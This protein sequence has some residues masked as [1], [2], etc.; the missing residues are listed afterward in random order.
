MGLKLAIGAAE[1]AKS[2]GVKHILTISVLT[3]SLTDTIYG[4]QYNE[5]ELK[6]QNLEMPYTIIRL[7][8]FVDNYWG[9]KLPIQQ[10]SSFGTP[11]DPTKP[12]SAVVV[13]DAGKAAAAIM[14]RPQEAL[15]Q[16]LQVDKQFTYTGRTSN[17]LQ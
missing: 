2:S 4:K 14:G 11:S 12:F 6:V 7:P 16:D 9:F 1:V 8:P 17:H 5:L 13:S 3:V 10:K 15:W